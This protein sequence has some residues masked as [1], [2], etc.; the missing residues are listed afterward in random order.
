MLPHWPPGTAAVLSVAGPRA[1]LVSTPIR[2]SD[3][4]VLFALGRRRDT[5]ARLREDPRAALCVLC[6]GLAFTAHGA[7]SVLAEELE[8]VPVAALELRVELV[9]DHLADGRTEMLG[10]AGWRWRSERDE[11]AA[12]AVA[13]Q[14]ALLA[15]HL[16]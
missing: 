6:E 12:R 1:I 4:R 2:A 15:R 8:R 3:E 14:L 7:V 13:E 11:Q 10:A 5:L 16:R 9:Q